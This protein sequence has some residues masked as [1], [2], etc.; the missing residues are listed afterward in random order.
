MYNSKYRHN[1]F[2]KMPIANKKLTRVINW[3]SLGMLFLGAYSTPK[4]LDSENFN[5]IISKIKQKKEF[6]GIPNSFLKK[7]LA[8]YLSKKKIQISSLSPYEIKLIVKDMRSLLRKYVGMF[9][10]SLKKRQ[11]LLNS[12]KI[13]K[14]LMAHSSTK[15]R[16]SIYPWLKEKIYSRKP[17]TILD[18]ACG[19]NPIALAKAGVEY[20][21]CDINEQDLL[22]VRE[23]FKINKIKGKVFSCD[24]KSYILSLPKT[25]ITL[26]LKILDI[27][28]KTTKEKFILAEK[29]LSKINSKI[30]IISFSTI[31]LSGKPMLHSKREWFEALLKKLNFQFSIEKTKNEIFYFVRK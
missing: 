31:S 4:N 5:S 23:F 7:E 9:S 6:Q 11:L 14:L 12:N 10:I 16:L 22:I 19:L 17:R 20:N 25:D 8:N 1:T 27:L 3:C 2:A 24:L 28:G 30:I 18:I 15:E 29:I 13:D 26:I 21:A